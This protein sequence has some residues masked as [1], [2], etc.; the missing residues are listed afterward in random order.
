M[1][2]M[3]LINRLTQLIFASIL[4]S[5][6]I[7]TKNVNSLISLIVEISRYYIVLYRYHI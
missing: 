6:S 7:V 5:G 4:W 3:S 1:L 2:N